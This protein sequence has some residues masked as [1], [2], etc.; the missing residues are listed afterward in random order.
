[1]MIIERDLKDKILP[2]MDRDEVILIIGSRQVGKT[3]LVRLLLDDIP[4]GQKVYFDLEDLNTLGILNQGPAA[5]VN[6][7]K[8]LGYSTEKKVVVALDEIQYLENPSNFIKIIHDHYPNIK[9][10]V[11]G[12][13]TL[14]IRQKFKDSLAG[15][16]IVFELDSMSF[17]EFLRF[18]GDSVVRIKEG[19]GTI[20][21]ILEGRFNSSSGLVKNELLPHLYEYLVFGGY[22]KAAQINDMNLKVSILNEVYSSY[23]RK[24]IKDIANIEDIFA[25]N[26]LIKLLSAQAGNMV[27]TN[28][29]AGTLGIN[30]A[31]VKKY[32]FLLENTFIAS[33]LNPYF[34]N[35]RKEISKMPKVYLLDNGLRNASLSSFHLF[36]GRSDRGVLFENYIFSELKRRYRINEEFFYWR[37]IAKAEV[38]FILNVNNRI[39]PL[40]V[41]A[42][43]MKS[44]ALTRSFR[45]FID[46]YKPDAGIVVNLSFSGVM[47]YGGCKIYFVPAYGI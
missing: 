6:Y 34:K 28:E 13:S 35:K 29:I 1:M 32:L 25:F 20:H 2:W 21:D 37:T 46:S 39:V 5:F 7:L 15:R 14:E 9:L 16:K 23:V 45:S 3:T 38:D 12:S 42:V 36:D 30:A 31:T 24:D 47:E 10:I 41:K 33:L 43:E 27:N 11:S 40:E 19:V 44:P 18:K 22:P 17:R 8:L 26:N 4:E